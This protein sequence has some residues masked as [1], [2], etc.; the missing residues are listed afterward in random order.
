M[1]TLNL[2]KTT[3]ESIASIL[4]EA[5][6]KIKEHLGFD[7]ELQVK[8]RSFVIDSS[9]L[10]PLQMVNYLCSKF[11]ITTKELKQSGR[12]QPLPIMKQ[13]ICYILRNTYRDISY[14]N[15]AS[16]VGFKDHTTALYHI[17][18][19][20][21]M[22]RLKDKKFMKYYSMAIGTLPIHTTEN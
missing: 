17:N 9:N 19:S 6:E 15:I 18:E 1:I 12:K 22:I 20:E 10:N 21:N 5:E 4:S 8:P 11:N 7:V 2:T 13:I 16:L 3:S 14:K